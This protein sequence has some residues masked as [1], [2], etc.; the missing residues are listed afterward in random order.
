ML[1]SYL[2][3]KQVSNFWALKTNFLTVVFPEQ[4]FWTLVRSSEDG[5]SPGPSSQDR[6]SKHRKHTELWGE[7]D[8]QCSPGRWAQTWPRQAHRAFL[9][10]KTLILDILFFLQLWVFFYT[11]YS[12]SGA[13]N[14]DVKESRYHETTHRDLLEGMVSRSV[15]WALEMSPQWGWQSNHLWTPGSLR[16]WGMRQKWGEQRMLVRI[17]SVIR[18]TLKIQWL[19]QSLSSLPWLVLLVFFFC[20]SLLGCMVFL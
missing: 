20:C 4:R 1:R 11:A 12:I 17:G 15:L 9:R 13:R 19:K 18:T 5:S 8:S 3:G 6:V 14:T 16:V 10:W 7:G 2:N